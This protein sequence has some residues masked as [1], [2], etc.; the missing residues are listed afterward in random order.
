MSHCEQSPV[1][2]KMSVRVFD[3]DDDDHHVLGVC[4]G[5]GWEWEHVWV[6]LV[7]VEPM[8]HFCQTGV[9]LLEGW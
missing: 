9:I 5:W 7:F 8:H 3:D 6:K 4:V 2:K 1:K